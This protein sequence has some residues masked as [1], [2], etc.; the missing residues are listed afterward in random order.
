MTKLNEDQ[1]HYLD[2]VARVKAEFDEEVAALRSQHAAEVENLKHA[3]YK[4]VSDAVDFRV[5][6]SR[7]GAALNTSD[8]KTIKSYFPA[9]FGGNA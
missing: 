3:L 1:Q 7:I 2:A 9:V 6:A 4:A 5:P 8:H